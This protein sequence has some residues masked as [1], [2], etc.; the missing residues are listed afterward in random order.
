MVRKIND[1]LT[2]I[3]GKISIGID[4]HLASWKVTALVEGEPFFTFNTP[5][6]NKGQ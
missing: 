3:K 5:T 1:R 4:V 6:M 2:K